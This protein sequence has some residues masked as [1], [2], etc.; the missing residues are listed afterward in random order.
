MN[1][2]GNLVKLEDTMKSQNTKIYTEE[3]ER[4]QCTETTTEHSSNL[5]DTDDNKIILTESAV[6]S[7]NIIHLY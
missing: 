4:K 1:F 7:I 6:V 5:L 3:P 2:S